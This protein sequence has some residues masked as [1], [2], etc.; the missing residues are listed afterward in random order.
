MEKK[1]QL[2]TLVSLRNDQLEKVINRRVSVRMLEELAKTDP[3]R[4]LA[5]TPDLDTLTPKPVTVRGRLKEMEENLQLDEQR[6][7]VLDQMITEEE[8]K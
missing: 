4:V 8:N 6:L 2:E 1:T 7:Q 3:N 5:V